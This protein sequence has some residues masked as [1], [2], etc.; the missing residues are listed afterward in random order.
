MIPKAYVV[1]R[2]RRRMRV[3]VPSR[4]G[5]ESYFSAVQEVLATLPDVEN[6]CVN[7]R[8]GSALIITGSD[9]AAIADAAM[10]HGLFSLEPGHRERTTL[11]DTVSNGVKAGNDRLLRFTGGELDIASMVFLF[12]LVSGVYQIMRGNVTVPAWYAAFY[13]A[14]HFFSKIHTDGEDRQGDGEPAPEGGEY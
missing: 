10:R 3:R 2:A 12:M 11:I 1:H 8:T 14:H 5:D 7:H 6:V 4:K 13:Y 9:V